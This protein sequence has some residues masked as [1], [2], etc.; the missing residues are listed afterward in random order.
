[1]SVASGSDKR[2]RT[3]LIAVRF[4]PKE[5]DALNAAA[6][7]AGLSVGAYLRKVALGE[8]GPRAVRRPPVEKKELAR[9]LGQLGK[10]GTDINQIA[11]RLNSDGAAPSQPEMA[12]MLEDLRSMRNVVLALQK[13]R[14]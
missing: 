4:L 10:V 13:H 12:Q 1:M 11:K 2:Q 6:D 14:P 5:A 9:I 7:L 3:R 8:P